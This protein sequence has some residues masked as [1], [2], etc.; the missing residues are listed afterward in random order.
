MKKLI[1]ILSLLT[2]AAC[3]TAKPVVKVETKPVVLKS[4]TVKKIMTKKEPC[5]VVGK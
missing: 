1:L 3:T 2:I 5:A 4:A